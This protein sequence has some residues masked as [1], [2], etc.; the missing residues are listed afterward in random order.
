MKPNNAGKNMRLQVQTAKRNVKQ[1]AQKQDAD[2][3]EDFSVLH[4]T[5][6]EAISSQKI[7]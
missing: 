6:L 2:G 5:Q 3:M 1:N 7:Y 4:V